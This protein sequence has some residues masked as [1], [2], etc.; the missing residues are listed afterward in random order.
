MNQTIVQS[1]MSLTRQLPVN[2]STFVCVVRSCEDVEKTLDCGLASPGQRQSRK[3]R[4]PEARRE[5]EPLGSKLN[6]LMA[7]V[8][9]SY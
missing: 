4:G 3:R 2:T 1:S 5:G 7:I 6:H 9:S 8:G